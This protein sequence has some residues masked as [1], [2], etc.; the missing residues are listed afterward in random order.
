MGLSMRYVDG[1]QN[2]D[3]CYVAHMDDTQ[4]TKQISVA[5]RA[6]DYAMIKRAAFASE[7]T[8]ADYVRETLTKAARWKLREKEGASA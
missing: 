8:L 3:V 4:S 5:V 6:D 1:T 7:Q 2:V